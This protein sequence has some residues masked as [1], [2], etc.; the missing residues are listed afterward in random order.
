MGENKPVQYEAEYVLTTDGNK[1]FIIMQF[2]QV[3]ATD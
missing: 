1:D 2:M 3:K